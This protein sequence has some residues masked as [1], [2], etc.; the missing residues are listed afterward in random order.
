MIGVKK[1]GRI[2]VHCKSKE[3]NTQVLRWKTQQRHRW[4][5]SQHL[6]IAEFK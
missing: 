2:Y 5:K 6:V 4:P 3:V 1:D